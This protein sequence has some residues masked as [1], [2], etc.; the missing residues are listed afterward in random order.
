MDGLSV[1]LRSAL[2]VAGWCVSNHRDACCEE[3]LSADGDHLLVP[4]RVDRLGWVPSCDRTSLLQIIY[5]LYFHRAATY[6]GTGEPEKRAE[7]REI[8]CS[9]R[10]ALQCTR[11]PLAM[12]AGQCRQA[13][14]FVH[15]EL[16]PFTGDST[17]QRVAGRSAK[18]PRP[19]S[20][21]GDGR[22]YRGWSWSMAACL[23]LPSHMSARFMS[24]R[25]K[26]VGPG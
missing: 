8:A 14:G 11:D 25:K 13:R 18:T 6:A 3:R 9:R 16:C 19:G 7:C 22:F 26:V 10:A 20:T 2:R 15:L 5:A 12:Q 23:R 4:R 1:E 24:P 17:N 21:E